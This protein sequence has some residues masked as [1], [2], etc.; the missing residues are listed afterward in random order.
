[1]C[2]EALIAKDT[3]GYA[4]GGL[5]G[6]EDKQD[7]WKIVNYCTDY[8]PE[9]KPRYLMGVGY[10]VDLIVCSCLGVD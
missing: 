4:I 10:P 3:N 6:G 5:A 1:M 7:F 8:L 2:L 9:N